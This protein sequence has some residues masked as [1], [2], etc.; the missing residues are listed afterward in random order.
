MMG[1]DSQS[2]QD[3]AYKQESVW[4]SGDAGY[5]FKIITDMRFDAGGVLAGK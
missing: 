4:S 5:K 1:W 2:N 3:F